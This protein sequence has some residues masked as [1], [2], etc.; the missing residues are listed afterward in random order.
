MRCKTTVSWPCVL[1]G[2]ELNSEKQCG[3]DPVLR[4]CFYRFLSVSFFGLAR[5]GFT[6]TVD[7]G[8]QVSQVLEVRGERRNPTPIWRRAEP[9]IKAVRIVDMS[10]SNA[11]PEFA[12]IFTQTRAAYR[13]HEQAQELD[14]AGC[15]GGDFEAKFG[16]SHALAAARLRGPA[17]SD[18]IQVSSSSW[19]PVQPFSELLRRAMEGR[20]GRAASRLQRAESPL[21]RAFEM[22]DPAAF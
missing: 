5:I 16:R 18:S 9:R 7:F 2:A 6:A 14:A 13:E 17:V 8:G 10:G 20:S 11:W 22:A 12:G 3:L 19:L 21:R 15:Q 4:C 1:G